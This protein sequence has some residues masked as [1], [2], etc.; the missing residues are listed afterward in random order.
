MGA[1]SLYLLKLNPEKDPDACWYVGLSEDPERRIEDHH[2]GNGVEWTGRNTVVD[3]WVVLRCPRPKAR[4]LENQLT[5]L[6]MLEFGIESTR[7]GSYTAPELLTLPTL[8][9]VLVH[10]DLEA[11]LQ[12]TPVDIGGALQNEAVRI[13]C[14]IEDYV[15][16]EGI[17]RRSGETNFSF[18]EADQDS[19]YA[20]PDAWATFRLALD[21]ARL[22]LRREHG[23]TEEVPK[24]ELHD[25]ALQ[26][27]KDAGEEIAE[28]VAQ[29]RREN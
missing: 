23:V 6:L 2:S 14:D 3:S 18:E 16:S 21:E 11:S 25:A 26:V 24:R 20:R 4:V 9:R 27:L 1:V 10:R 17:T 7:G 19:L 15:F 22:E 28:Q 13:T 12:T 5:E 8:G 29:Q